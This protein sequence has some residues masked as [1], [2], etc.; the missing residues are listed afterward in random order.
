MATRCT[1][2][3]RTGE[4]CQ[5]FAIAKSKYCFSHAP[6]K[7]KERTAARK[8]GGFNRRTVHSG[9]PDQVPREIRSMDDVL[10][11]LDYTLAECLVQENSIS[12]GR[13]LVTVVNSYIGA[14]QEGEFEMRLKLLEEKVNG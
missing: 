14:I 3:N 11:L 9:D 2:K 1:A 8:L 6:S 13:L 12:R 5:G 4:P 10:R 7:R